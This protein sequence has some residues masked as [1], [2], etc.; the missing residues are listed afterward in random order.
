MR[1]S[2]QVVVLLFVLLFIGCGAGDRRGRRPVE[3]TVTYLGQPVANGRIIFEPVATNLPTAT[4]QIRDGI[5]EIESKYG[6]AAG[7][8]SVRIEGLR[9]KR[10][11][12]VPKHPYLGDD[13]QVGVVSEQFL[14]PKYNAK[15]VLKVE[16][17]KDGSNV[18]NFDL[19]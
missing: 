15:S 6:P 1:V 2:H 3:G 18:H 17:K 11:P 13:Q 4:A 12:S 8:C 9:E 14:P 19:K 7:E 16:I 10:D 5:Y